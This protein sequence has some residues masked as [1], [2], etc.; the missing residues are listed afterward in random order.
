[1]IGIAKAKAPAEESETKLI[2]EV[3]LDNLTLESVLPKHSKW[4]T[5]QIQFIK[6]RSI[7]DA[8]VSRL[9][10]PLSPKSPSGSGSTHRSMAFPSTTRMASTGFDCTSWGRNVWWR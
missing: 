2:K 7:R 4:A 5:S 3:V 6:D 9:T 8:M 10:T 1:M